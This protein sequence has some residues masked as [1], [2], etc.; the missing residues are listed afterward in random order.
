M[1]DGNVNGVNLVVFGSCGW[2]SPFLDND[3]DNFV[4]GVD[5]D[6]VVIYG[7]AYVDYD[8][9]GVSLYQEKT[10]FSLSGR[11]LRRQCVLCEFGW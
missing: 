2:S 7:I 4:N 11:Q 8:S 5:D 9:Y 6:G 1:S 3:E 10:T